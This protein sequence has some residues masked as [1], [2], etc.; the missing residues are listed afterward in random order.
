MRWNEGNEI[1]GF[2]N[3]NDIAVFTVLVLLATSVV[4]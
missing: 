3:D 1:M 2:E 4:G